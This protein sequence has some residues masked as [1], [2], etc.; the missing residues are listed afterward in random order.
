MNFSVECGTRGLEQR[1]CRDWVEM[2]RF[3]PPLTSFFGE[4][5]FT[6]RLME[7]VLSV[8][9]QRWTPRSQLDQPLHRGLPRAYGCSELSGTTPVSGPLPSEAA[10]QSGKKRGTVAI[11][12]KALD[13]CDKPF[14]AASLVPVSALAACEIGV[15]ISSSTAQL[16]GLKLTSECINNG[17][18]F[19][20]LYKL[21]D[22]N[23]TNGSRMRS[24]CLFV[25][26]FVCF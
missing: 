12:V 7:L 21:G 20:T 6:P 24:F 26:L 19:R 23:K 9:H 25:C 17:V 16:T 3:K 13:A 15:V 18:Q 1:G 5:W 8:W 14:S 2:Y 11:R 10:W 4:C 22:I